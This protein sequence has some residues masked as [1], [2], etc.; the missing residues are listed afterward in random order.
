[1]KNLSFLFFI[2]LFGFNGATLFSQ[3]KYQNGYVVTTKNDTI[4]G[5]LRDRSPEPFGKIFTKVRMKGFWIFE[6]RFGPK[7]LNS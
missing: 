6:G 2:L 5:Q 4:Y 3:S 7:D 1:M